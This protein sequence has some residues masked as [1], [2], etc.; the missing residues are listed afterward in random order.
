MRPPCLVYLSTK[1]SEYFFVPQSPGIPFCFFWDCRIVGKGG[2]GTGRHG[3]GVVLSPFRRCSLAEGVAARTERVSTVTF[4]SASYFLSE[5]GIYIV[6]RIVL[7]ARVVKSETTFLFFSF[8]VVCHLVPA[9]RLRFSVNAAPSPTM[10]PVSSP[11]PYI[12]PSIHPSIHPSIL[13]LIH[14]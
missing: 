13:S 14:I 4:A 10:P 8:L 7:F 5:M 11:R 3:E 2:S 12:R 1:I 9:C 6:A